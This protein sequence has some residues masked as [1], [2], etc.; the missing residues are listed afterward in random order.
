MG[1]FFWR[2]ESRGRRHVA[3]L[4]RRQ[5]R[6]ARG[7]DQDRL[8]GSRR[9]YDF[10]GGLRLLLQE[11]K[12]VSGGIEGASRG[13]RHAPGE[14]NAQETG[15]SQEPPAGERALG[16]GAVYAGDDGDYFESVSDRPLVAGSSPLDHACPL[17]LY[18]FP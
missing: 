10:D 15:R 2:R 4:A 7:D 6:G 1:L 16:L 12:E 11:W 5:G 8:A 3:R 9:F 13:T 14:S 17:P 18:H